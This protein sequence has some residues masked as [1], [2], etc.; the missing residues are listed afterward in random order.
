MN[1]PYSKHIFLFP[2]KWT[3]KQNESIP[4][5]Q[6]FD[7]YL[8]LSLWEQHLFDFSA[9]YKPLHPYNN[10]FY[11]YPAVREI[12]N[13][14][15]RA[16]NQKY[17]RQYKVRC[18]ANKILGDYSIKIK[19]IK[20]E[21]NLELNLKIED[22][23]LNIFDYGVGVFSIHLTNVLESDLNKILKIN[24][25]GR[26]VCPQ[27][28][29]NKGEYTNA[30]KFN[31]LADNITIHLSSQNL[32]YSE[33][34]EH[35]NLEENLNR[36]PFIVPKFIQGVLG[37]HF[38][39]IS[40]KPDTTV[41]LV[42]LL[43]DRMFV[44]S[45]LYNENII[46][47]LK[48]YD[49][50]LKKYNYESSALWYRYLFIDDSQPSCRNQSLLPEYIKK[51]TY[52]RWIEDNQIFGVS[53]YSFVFIS[54][55]EEFKRNVI[56]QHMSHMYFEMSMHCLI[57]RAFTI[58]FG[59]EIANISKRLEHG[60][61]PLKK[62][63]KDISNL[64][65]EYIRFKNRIYFREVSAQDQGIELY[66]L[67]QEHMCIERDVKNLGEEIQELNTY[68]DTYEQSNLS[69]V[70]TMFLPI[71]LLAGVLGINTL[72]GLF[73]SKFTL[74]NINLEETILNSLSFILLFWAIILI[75]IQ[76]K[77]SIRI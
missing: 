22:I 8:D 67:L 51:H 45:S 48:G 3:L 69:K 63:R 72:P 54:S 36:S 68:L 35:Y 28:L 43:D 33:N 59:T 64:Y 18:G 39:P 15:S 21:L 29:G 47:D 57:Q 58:H 74:E 9:E 1:P 50:N 7:T 38:G 66:S 73:S 65:L 71:T 4:D 30:T 14:D 44:L 34:F 37:D 40:T 55:D 75:F 60:H 52:A 11:F 12:L 49:N 16:Q 19:G 13:L 41:Q 77:K 26:R 56:G 42:P 23:L 24:E 2:F 61:A 46:N 20:T 32:K 17:Q 31:F 10:Y 5:L 76:L 53:R 27:Y 70:A 25:Y 62:I 6:K